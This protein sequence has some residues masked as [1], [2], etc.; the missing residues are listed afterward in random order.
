MSSDEGKK[1][2]GVTPTVITITTN[3]P[4]EFHWGRQ[5]VLT[6]I[7]KVEEYFE[8]FYDSSKKKKAVWEAV[9]QSMKE[10]GYNCSG[11]DC[12]KKWR[13]LKGTYVKVLQKQING[14]SGFRFE[15]FDALH[16]ILGNEID[17]L[18]MR[19]EALTNGKKVSP[20]VS[21]LH[22]QYEEMTIDGKMTWSD[23][24]TRKLLELL[25]NHHPA[26]CSFNT[27]KHSA[28]QEVSQEMNETGYEADRNQCRRKWQNLREG[29][30]YHEARAKATGSVPLWAYYIQ[31]RDLVNSAEASPTERPARAVKRG[32]S[33]PGGRAKVGKHSEKSVLGRVQQLESGGTVWQRL[34]R[35]EAKVE[36]SCRQSTFKHT[37]T[38]LTQILSELRT[39]NSMLAQEGHKDEIQEPGSDKQQQQQQQNT[40]QEK[41]LEQQDESSCKNNN[42][43]AAAIFLYQLRSNTPPVISHDCGRTFW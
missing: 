12:D 43:G 28:W 22:A 7:S 19:E 14:E 10:D 3:V 21:S 34:E 29:F 32:R 24:A 31:V 33:K 6:L 36:A 42:N 26:L 25:G 17:P 41:E 30:H 18:G 35:L 37:N 39:I 13:N 5:Q 27:T 15:Y 4:R 8:D 2:S 40:V 9:A 16:H 38:I 20:R 11:S 23:T 1:G